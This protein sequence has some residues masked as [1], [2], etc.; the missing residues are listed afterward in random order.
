MHLY[1][2]SW[3]V[4]FLNKKQRQVWNEEAFLGPRKSR[5]LNVP[6]IASFRRKF[7]KWPIVVRRASKKKFCRFR[8]RRK[9]NL[10]SEK[11][12]S[13]KN[14]LRWTAL[15]HSNDKKVKIVIM[16]VILF[17]RTTIKK[18]SLN[19]CF[20]KSTKEFFCSKPQICWTAKTAKSRCRGRGKRGEFTTMGEII[21][22]PELWTNF[23]F[24]A[25]DRF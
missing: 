14:C 6:P 19:G 8:F 5:V 21:F 20:E 9:K 25:G 18:I 2:L 17:Q 7:G 12:D 24:F 1:V 22:T 23:D 13:T 10:I 15:D 4:S 16:F 3:T 11:S